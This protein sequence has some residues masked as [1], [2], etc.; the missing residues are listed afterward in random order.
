MSFRSKPVVLGTTD[1]DIYESGVGL[2]SVVVLGIHNVNGSDRTITLKFYKQA[3]ATTTEFVTTATWAAKKSDK[4]AVPFSMEPGDKIVG[5][6]SSTS[7]IVVTPF[8][9]DNAAI[10]NAVGFEPLGDWNSETIYGQNDIVRVEGVSSPYSPGRT[11]I[12]MQPNN[13]GNA[14]ASS[15]SY[16]MVLTEDGPQGVPGELTSA[17]AAATYSAIK[18]TIRSISGTSDTL[19]IGDAGNLV[20]STN[21]SGTTITVPPN[22]SVAFEIGTQIDFT[23]EGAGQVTFAQGDG[24]TIN[25]SDSKKKINKRYESATLIKT[26]TNTW[27]LIGSLAT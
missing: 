6:A 12:S 24:V 22:S 11:Y 4:F 21:G 7:S 19:V 3:T 9:T 13:S 15:P 27:T 8:I 25:S 5:L 14:P 1:T 17:E 23:Q 16:W 20:Q 10:P 2:S 18:R 26:A